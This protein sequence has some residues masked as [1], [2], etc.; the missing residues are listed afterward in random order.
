[1]YLG[2]TALL[3]I[4]E[5]QTAGSYITPERVIWFLGILLLAGSNFVQLR[6]NRVEAVHETDTTTIR[7]LQ[8]ALERARAERDELRPDAEQ[9]PGVKRELAALM[10]IDIREFM[11]VV[12]LTRERDS[13]RRECERLSDELAREKQ[14]G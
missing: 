13:Y 2:Q 4:Q 1:M 9:L 12:A 14:K 11:G 3:L 6:H 8:L 7:S 10:A 5:A